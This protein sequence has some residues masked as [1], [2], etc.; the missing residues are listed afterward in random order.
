[1]TDDRDRRTK[2]TDPSSLIPHPSSLVL[3]SASPRRRELLA[4]LGLPFDVV[5]ADV[6]ESVAPGEDAAAAAVRLA[7]S[8][9]E[10]VAWREW[11]ALV[12]GADT[13]VVLDGR[14]LGKPADGDEAAD[15]LRDL[16]GREHTVITGVAVIDSHSGDTRTAA[17]A[18]TVRMRAYADAEVAASIAAGT[19]FD[20]AGAYAIQDDVFSPVAGIDGCYCNVVGLPLWTVYRLLGG[21]AGGAAVRPPSASRTVCASCP[22]SPA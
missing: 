7:R 19:P 2:T 9:A 22:M 4:A 8:K 17:P 11:D 6:D 5:A 20:K 16:R 1:M 15:M 10:A 13:V 12:L 21:L 14:I 18:T 3:A